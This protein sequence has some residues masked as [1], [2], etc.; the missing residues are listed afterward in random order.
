MIPSR[1]HCPP[2]FRFRPFVEWLEDRTT[3]AGNVVAF[4]QNGVLFVYGDSEGNGVTVEATGRRSVVVRPDADTTL[5]GQA[6]GAFFGGI[7]HGYDVR[8]G[9]GND[10]VI[11]RGL[12]ADWLRVEGGVGDDVISLVG[13]T[14]RRD[15]KIFGD[16]GADRIEVVNSDF[17]RRTAIDA[18]AGDDTLTARDSRFGKDTFFAG[19]GGSNGLAETANRFRR[20]PSVTGFAAGGVAVAPPL[21]ADDA[22]TVAAGSAVTIPVLANDAARGGAALVPTTV[23]LASVT[24]LGT[25][26]VNPD[27]TVTFTAGSNSGTATFQYVVRDSNGR[28]SNPATVTVTITGEATGPTAALSTSSTNPSAAAAVPFTA[29]FSAG[30]NGFAPQDLTVT[31]GTAANFIEVNNRTYTF[32]VIPAGDGPVIVAIPGGVAADVTTGQGNQASGGVSVTSIRTDQGMTNTLPDAND[33][34]FVASPNGLRVWDVEVGNGTPVEAD[35]T[36]TVFYTG[37]LLDGTVFDQAR[38]V[39]EPATFP[40][41]NL[42]QG[43]QQGLIGMQAGGIRRLYIPSALGYGPTGSPPRI[44]GNADLIFEIKLVV[45]T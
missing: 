26:L 39:G 17:R 44:P 3:P 2:G 30:V 10:G 8:T 45:A 5:N 18:G 41:Q 36:I 42:I 23:Q 31:N 4:V 24:A 32:D 12:D 9:A 15:V 16:D 13:V 33:P 1:P 35:S 14:N 25:G 29:V 21:A 6:A 22:A 19:Q 38:T 11:L 34:N 37:W 7:K 20:S 40:L 43:W 27:G 28:T